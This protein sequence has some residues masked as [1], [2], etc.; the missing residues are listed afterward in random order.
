MTTRESEEFADAEARPVNCDLMLNESGLSDSDFKNFPKL[1][2]SFGSDSASMV[3]DSTLPRLEFS[4]SGEQEEL[5]A[6]S[7]EEL[8]ELMSKIEEENASWV[9]DKVKSHLIRT[10]DFKQIDAVIESLNGDELQA[11][12]KIASAEKN[13]DFAKANSIIQEVFDRDPNRFYLDG[14][15]LVL[16]SFLQSQAYSP[17]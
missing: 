14:L 7:K 1:E 11:M 8:H 2:N 5:Q 16:E 4:F 10:S 13:G 6:P 12:A 15:S 17:K 3:A 9:S